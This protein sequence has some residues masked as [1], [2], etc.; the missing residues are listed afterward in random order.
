MKRDNGERRARRNRIIALVAGVITAVAIVLAF[1]SEYLDLPWK[2]VRPAAELFLLGELV[3][4]VV[5]ERHQLFEPVHETVG[6]THTL[7]R[8]IHSMVADAARDA[9]QVNACASTPEVFAATVRAMR[10]ALT[11]EHSAPQVLRIARLS[12]SM[13]RF[14]DPDLRGEFEAFSGSIAAFLLTP[15]TASPDPRA[16]RWL[17]R[18]IWAFASQENLDYWLQ[19]LRQICR[20]SPTNLEVKVMVRPRIDAVLSPAVI[21]DRDVVLTFDDATSS[22]RWGFRFQ[23]QQHRALLERW[24]D[25]LWANIPD[26]YRIYSRRGFS[27]DAIERVRTELAAIEKPQAS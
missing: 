23:G 26:T 20:E 8:E 16:L 25:D 12:G 2:W 1:A 4:L 6:G 7:V 9:G 24:F 19:Q 11:R 27:D 14:E 22:F 10:D 15:G 13:R 21:T 18:Q 17:V 5:L 3:G